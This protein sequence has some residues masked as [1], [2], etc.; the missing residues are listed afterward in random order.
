[1]RSVKKKD[2]VVACICVETNL[3]I[4]A[5]IKQG[6]CDGWT[7]YNDKHQWKYITDE[8]SQ[9]IQLNAPRELKDDLKVKEGLKKLLAGVVDKQD[10]E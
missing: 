5:P 8:K 1:M 10:I 4:V 6:K 9:K 2:N 3:Y 7:S